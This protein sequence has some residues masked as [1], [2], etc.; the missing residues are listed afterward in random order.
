MALTVS[1]RGR[2][3]LED[4]PIGA[5]G[6]VLLNNTSLAANAGRTITVPSTGL[7]EIIMGPGQ[8]HIDETVQF[9][10]PLTGTD[11]I[12]SYLRARQTASTTLELTATQATYIF[13]IVEV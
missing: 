6:T 2:T 3:G 12:G 7:L 11:T 5:G 8:Y 1:R 10:L 9:E 13:D 4:I